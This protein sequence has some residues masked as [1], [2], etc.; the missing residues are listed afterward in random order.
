MYRVPLRRRKGESLLAAGAAQ[1]P[2]NTRPAVSPTG[3]LTAAPP[4]PGEPVNWRSP[5][6]KAT[7]SNAERDEQEAGGDAC[8]GR[9]R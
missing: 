1:Q 9:Q 4:T 8:A 5:G 7:Q 6:P 2:K 3:A